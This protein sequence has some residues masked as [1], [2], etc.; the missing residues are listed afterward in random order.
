MVWR[1]CCTAQHCIWRPGLAYGHQLGTSSE[2]GALML[3]AEV[4][5]AV[6]VRLIRWHKYLEKLVLA[7]V[8]AEA[9]IALLV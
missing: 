1:S 5:A 7:F 4:S 2:S 8:P 9:P 3:L 6:R